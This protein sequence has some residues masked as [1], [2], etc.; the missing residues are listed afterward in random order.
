ME[1]VNGF[2]HKLQQ[3]VFQDFDIYQLLR[4]VIIVG[5]YI[6]LR[7]RVSEYLKQQQLKTQL[8]HDKAAKAEKL[9]N[10]PTGEAA[11]AEAAELF[12]E[13]AGIAKS[14]ANWGWGKT[15]RRKVKKQQAAF[16]KEIERAA[17]DAQR[18]LDSGYNSDDEIN[19]F[20]QD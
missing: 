13:H 5:G 14:E 6:F 19:E 11:E 7:T 18:K 15:T 2:V 4:L 8:E 16:E 10:D 20:L 17:V 3:K 1:F 9:I 12:G